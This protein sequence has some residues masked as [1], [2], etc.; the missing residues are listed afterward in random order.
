MRI[1][2]NSR[3]KST[4]TISGIN[5]YGT[6]TIGMLESLERLGYKVS[7]NDPTADVGLCFDQPQHWEFYGNQYK[8]GYLPWESTVLMPGWAKLMN[9]CDEIWTPSPIVAAW[10]KQYNDVTAPV[11]VYEHGIGPE[12]KPQRRQPGDKIRFLNIGGE[13]TRKLGW[14][15][16]DTWRTVFVDDDRVTYTMK[17]VNT[18]WNKFN[19]LRG[20]KV[21]FLS[22]KM[23]LA[24]L[25][26]LFYSHDI[27]VYNSAGEG[28]GLT[29]FQAIASGMPT[30]TPAKWAPYGN[31]LDP[32][33][34]VDSELK[35]TPWPEL[36][37]GDVFIPDIKSLGE[38]MLYA[39]EHFNEIADKAFETAPKVHELY[40]WDAV[41]SKTFIALENRLKLLENK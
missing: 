35:R 30:I 41:T 17:T 34:V 39:V 23:D 15:C 4:D 40:N 21:T 25:Q 19:I 7:L 28:W 29:P 36:H 26:D 20:G 24:S 3:I 31:L 12:W 37:P 6:A 8:I 14:D 13:A 16:L 10:F 22:N 5:G 18:D 27:Y 33:L 2:F 11:Y 38:R 9:Q 32:N 1:S